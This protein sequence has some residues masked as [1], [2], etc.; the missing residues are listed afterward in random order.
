MNILYSRGQFNNT[1]RKIGLFH[2]RAY[3][4]FIRGRLCRCLVPLE[5]GSKK[6]TVLSFNHI[7]DNDSDKEMYD[8]A[9]KIQQRNHNSGIVEYLFQ[10][11]N[12]G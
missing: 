2:T 7:I 1:Y 4:S 8:Q 12:A 3:G 6:A 10:C 9:S 11:G 5:C